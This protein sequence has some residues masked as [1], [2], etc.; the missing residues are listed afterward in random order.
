MRLL[1]PVLILA[2]GAA[3]AQAPYTRP[4]SHATHLALGLSCLDCHAPAERSGTP[5]DNLL[6]EPELCRRCHEASP[7]RPARRTLV[8]HFSHQ[9]HLKLGDAGPAIL[10][11]IRSG[12]HLAPPPV[13]AA[14]PLSGAGACGACHRGASDQS[15]GMPAM[16]DCLVCHA[17]IEPPFSCEKCHT[18]GPELKPASHTPQYLEEHS[19]PGTLKDKQGC[20]VCHGR[21]FTCLGCH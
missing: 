10:A 5:G 9:L 20:A 1:A 4:F 17:R 21:R 2:L 14:R 13:D 6:P 7:I 8:A 16:A 11:A 18:P 15:P 3:L 19:R 12:R